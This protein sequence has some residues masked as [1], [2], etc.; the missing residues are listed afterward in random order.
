MIKQNIPYQLGQR[1]A[2]Y[3]KAL[4]LL[5]KSVAE[6]EKLDL[7]QI[8]IYVSSEN[9]KDNL[10]VSSATIA[11]TDKDMKKLGFQ[12]ILK[13]IEAEEWADVWAER[14]KRFNK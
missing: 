1:N 7:M 8:A 6:I 12:I 9:I 2:Y 3:E 5:Q 14:I 4:K 13:K 11:S 10:K